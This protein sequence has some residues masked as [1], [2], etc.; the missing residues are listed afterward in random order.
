MT[1]SV[2]GL[3]T[4]SPRLGSID[5]WKA[6]SEYNEGSRFCAPICGSSTYNE[7][8]RLPLS[9]CTSST[10]SEGWRSLFSIGRSGATKPNGLLGVL[11]PTSEP[12]EDEMGE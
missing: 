3:P 4:T 8:S 6:S 7:G 11:E 9:N 10:Y 1:D 2:E 12:K 5:E